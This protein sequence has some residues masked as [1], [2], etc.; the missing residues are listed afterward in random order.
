MQAWKREQ[1]ANSTLSHPHPFITKLKYEL[2][3][4]CP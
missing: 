4:I 3:A 1:A 2:L